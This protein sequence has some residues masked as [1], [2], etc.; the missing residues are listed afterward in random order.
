MALM[1]VDLMVVEKVGKRVVRMVSMMAVSTV[2]KM[3]D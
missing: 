2:D 1:M 3:V